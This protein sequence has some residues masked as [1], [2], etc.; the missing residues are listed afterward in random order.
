MKID[1]DRVEILTSFVDRLIQLK[2]IS[3]L[4]EDSI[5]ELINQAITFSGASYTEDEID[6]AR[7]DIT[8]RYQIRTTPGESILLDYDMEN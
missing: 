4:S 5:K 7:K 2:E 3:D 6:M 8:S 1:F